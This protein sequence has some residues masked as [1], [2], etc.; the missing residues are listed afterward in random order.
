MSLIIAGRYDTYPVAEQAAARL[1]ARGFAEDDVTLFFVNPPG[2]HARY[3][4]GGDR[5]A[6]PGARRSGLGAGRGIVIGAVAGAIAGVGIL[7]AFGAAPL[8]LMLATGVGAYLGSL[9]G[10]LALARQDAG[11]K[12]DTGEKAVRDAG[13]LLAVHV[14]PDTGAQAADILRATGARDVERARGRWNNGRWADFDP[15]APPVPAGR[16][17]SIQ[18]D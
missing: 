16:A 18:E 13:V 14:Q 15:L 3:P 1:F 5:G 11:R 2:Q 9:V 10:A 7:A 4:I 6:D 12:P 8:L 17:S